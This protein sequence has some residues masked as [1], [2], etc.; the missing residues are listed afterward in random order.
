MK[1]W[2]LLLSVSLFCAC[3][4]EPTTY[5]DI[6]AG[7]DS[8]QDP[9]TSPET[10][11]DTVDVVDTESDTPTQSS[12]TP[13][14][15]SEETDDGSDGTT[16]DSDTPSE[17]PDTCEGADGHDEDGDGR[18]D[19]C[20]N[21]PTYPNPQQKD[22]DADGL[23][24]AC[25][26]ED[27]ELLSMLTVFDPFVE[28][29][30]PW[31]GDSGWLPL[32]DAV[33]GNSTEQG[34]NAWYEVEIPDTKAYSVEA[35]FTLSQL[36]YDDNN[37]AGVVFARHDIP[38]RTVWWACLYERESGS[39]GLWYNNGISIGSVAEK[40]NADPHRDEAGILRKVRVYF[41]P[42]AS[43]LSCTLENEY[44]VRETISLSTQYVQT[45][46]GVSGIRVYEER[47]DFTSFA[48]YQ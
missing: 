28:I 7:T 3:G 4:A 16:P 41:D 39:L 46:A 8:N 20:D 23:G 47:A 37:Y 2:L 1:R 38:D 21:C 34:I 5:D 29:D 9:D 11:D 32:E 31:K 12:D 24:D 22:G 35:T 30:D 10:S 45:L 36:N 15:A 17:E 43:R 40:D 19:A 13:S 27:D 18:I 44:G 26:A 14:T 25:E 33:R 48:V 42:D 6:V